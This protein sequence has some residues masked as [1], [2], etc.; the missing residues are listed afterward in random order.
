MADEALPRQFVNFSFYRV[1]PLWRRLPRAERDRGRAEFIE[2]VQQYSKKLILLN[3]SLVGIRPDCDFMIWRI[4]FELEPFQEMSSRLNQTGLGQYLTTPHSYL[5]VTKRSIYVD[6]H[7]HP[8]QE[9]RRGQITPGE[10][11]Y[12][13]VYPFVKTRDWYQLPFPERQKM[14]DAHIA[15]GH[16]Y[17][18]IKINTTY[19]FGIDDQE[20]VV[21]FDGEDPKEFVDLV[22]ELREAA[23]SKYTVRDTPAFTCLKKNS[24][25]EVLDQL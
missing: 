7:I 22:Q 19:S 6:K 11:K 10:G 12:L 24:M 14:M 13:F 17:P 25:R 15:V 9:G 20:F 16:K 23:S 1:D 4:G 21:A 8:G 2:V 3:Y 18:S 5:A